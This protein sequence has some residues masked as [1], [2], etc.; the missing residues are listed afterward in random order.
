MS[1]DNKKHIR[2]YAGFY[3]NHF[4]RS[5][6][7]YIMAKILLKNNINYVYEEKSYKLETLNCTYKP[8]FTIYD[9]DGKIEKIIEVKGGRGKTL[10]KAYEKAHALEKEYNIKVDVYDVDKIIELCKEN[11]LKFYTLTKQWKKDSTLT[12]SDICSGENNP[13]YG[14]HHTDETKAKL[15]AKALKQWER[16]REYIIARTREEM[17][18]VDMKEIARKSNRHFANYIQKECLY[19]GKTFNVSEGTIKAK[20]KKYCSVKC[21]NTHKNKTNP[22]VGKKSNLPKKEIKNKILNICIENKEKVLEAK[23]NNITII[24]NELF[25]DLMVEYNIKDV[26]TLIWCYFDN[27]EYYRKDFIKSLKQYLENVC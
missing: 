11:D 18:K 17:A 19:C 25:N 10:A 22:L 13:M 5:S 26:R 23:L 3:N 6:Y 1:I 27:H 14:T 2:G 4:V 24:I 12:S 7:E 15:R 20:N 9:K 21:A 16:D 8:D